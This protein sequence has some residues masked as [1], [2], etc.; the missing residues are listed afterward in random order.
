[1]F[2]SIKS[3]LDTIFDEFREAGVTL[4]ALGLLIMAV[5]TAFGGEENK[6]TFQRGVIVCIVGMVIF[7]L[8]K[9]IVRF[10]QGEL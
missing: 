8:A 2:D 9:P 5:M 1:M 7:F 4:F 10:F 6:R 3:L